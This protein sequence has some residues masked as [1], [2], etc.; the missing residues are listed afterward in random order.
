MRHRTFAAAIGASCVL[1]AAALGQQGQFPGG[2]GPA[3]EAGAGTQA[4]VETADLSLVF[5][6]RYAVPVLL[7][8]N[9]KVFLMAPMDGMLKSVSAAVGSLV[10]DNQEIVQLDRAE[11]AAKAKIAAAEVREAEAL[12]AAEDSGGFAT[13]A[14]ARVAGPR[15]EAAK[16]RAE[17]AQIELDRCTLR[18]P[19][20]GKIV[21]AP[22]P[23]GQ[24][25]SKGN[26][27]AELADTS[28]LKV[29]VPV[30]RTIVKPGGD[31]EMIIEGQSITA[32]VMA[33]VPMPE[34]YAALRE[35]AV[36]WAGAWVAINNGSGALEPGQ[37]V[38]GPFTPTQPVTAVPTRALRSGEGASGLV[39]V[40]R[41]G[42]VLDIPVK[43]L[44]DAG[45]ERT[46][47]SGAFLA[48][49]AAI[50]NSTVPL[51]AGTIIRFSGDPPV[52][53]LAG[54]IAGAMVEVTP[55]VGGPVAPSTGRVAPIGSPDAG[56][57]KIG[58]SSRP[59]GGTT[60]SPGKKAA[61]PV[62]GNPF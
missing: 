46:Q 24:Y 39:Q 43:V 7:E 40:I 33:T 16:A 56:L 62:V 61:P 8:P 52:S 53:G 25:V 30:D 9:R 14:Q 13:A 23:A 48:T 35:L 28:I 38:R 50:V 17:L 34:T 26:I 18:A 2:A 51:V 5:P 12:L 22:V 47:V 41:F 37:R 36:P 55:P 3:A 58:A 27:L 10:R 44:G 32:K 20:G 19:F 29:L 21:E 60:K 59:K 57:P 11:A 49:D 15:L 42:H 1:A 54:A 4:S 31:L 6:D 45:F